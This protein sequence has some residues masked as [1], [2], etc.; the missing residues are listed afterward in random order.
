MRYL[1]AFLLLFASLYAKNVVKI[2]TENLPPYQYKA[3]DGTLKGICVDIV[4]AIE[5]KLHIKEPIKL[6]PWTRGLKILNKKPNTALFSM[7]KTKER[8]PHYQWVGPLVKIK[9]IFFKKKGSN[10]KIHTLN[11][12]KKLKKIGVTKNFGNYEMLKAKGFKNLDVITTGLDTKNIKKLL[13]G[14]IDLWPG[15][16]AQS[17]YTAK[18]MGF[19]G[20]IVPLDDFI[21]SEGDFYIAFNKKSDPKTVQAWQKALDALKTDGTIDAIKARYP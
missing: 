11:D 7:L 21:I 15:L 3:K 9:M 2:M 1:L 10:I 13:H 17:L 18:Q 16:R 14:R 8:I 6:Y 5:H 19:E 20:A 12:A 4:K